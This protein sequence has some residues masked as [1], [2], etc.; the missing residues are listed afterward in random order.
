MPSATHLAPIKAEAD[1]LR[2]GEISSLHDG[3]PY[4]SCRLA[5]SAPQLGHT[6]VIGVLYKSE[7]GGKQKHADG[8]VAASPVRLRHVRRHFVLHY[9]TALRYTW[10]VGLVG[11]L[12][13]GGK[14][15]GLGSDML[16]R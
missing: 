5:R 14:V 7:V 12:G 16:E 1:Q 3:R 13:A 15:V 4:S 10:E 9:C 11:R 8:N 2:K 6:H